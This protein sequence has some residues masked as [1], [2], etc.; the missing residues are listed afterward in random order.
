LNGI[1]LGSGSSRIH[2]RD[3]QSRV[4]EALGFSQEE[5]RQRFGFLLDALE[6]GGRTAS[7]VARAFSRPEACSTLV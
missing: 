4:F 1:E 6:Y 3:V 5:A 7:D 2:R